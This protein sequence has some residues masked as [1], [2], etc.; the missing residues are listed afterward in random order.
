M[1]QKTHRIFY[2]LQLDI[3]MYLGKL[4]IK[5]KENNIFNFKLL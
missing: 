4:M 3:L 2:S 1:L 5:K